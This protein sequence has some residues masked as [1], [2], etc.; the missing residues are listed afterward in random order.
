MWGSTS[1]RSPGCRNIALVPAE[2]GEI[3]S[4]TVNAYKNV[5]HPRLDP[6]RIQSEVA[7]NERNPDKK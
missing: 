4:S 5:E 3:Q 6:S 7:I 2:R 1:R